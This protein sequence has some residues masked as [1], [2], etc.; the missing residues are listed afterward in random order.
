M[1]YKSLYVHSWS[2]YLSFPDGR[3]LMVR[4]NYDANPAQPGGFKE[5]SITK[6]ACRQ[7]IVYT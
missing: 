2:I 7:G 5:L 3:I 4:H 1:K 6:G